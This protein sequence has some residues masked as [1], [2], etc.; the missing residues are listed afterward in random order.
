MT[1]AYR[2]V[3]RLAAG[4]SYDQSSYLQTINYTAYSTGGV[5][6]YSKQGYS[7]S[8]ITESRGTDDVPTTHNDWDNWETDRLDRIDIYHGTNIV[9]RYDLGYNTVSHTDGSPSTTWKT[10]T[11]TSVAISGSRTITPL[12]SLPTTTFTY[13]DKDNRAPDPNN[14]GSIEWAYP[15]L[16]TI[17]NGWGATST[18]IYEHDGRSYTSWY[19]WRVNQLNITDGVN[20]SPMKSTFSYSAPCYNDPS[21]YWC[22]P[23]NTG[24]LVGYAQTTVINFDFN[25]TT[26]LGKVVHMFSTGQFEHAVETETRYQDGLGV[27]VK[28]TVTQYD[29]WVTSGVPPFG[30]A[31]FAYPDQVDEY[32][33]S[34]GSLTLTD[35]TTYAYDLATGN[36]LSKTDYDASNLSNPYR[37][38]VYEYVTNPSPDVWIIKTVSK[39]KVQDAGGVVLSEQQYGYN[40]NLP[41]YTT[42][43]PHLTNKPDLSWVVNGTQT[44]DTKYHY[45]SYGN[46]DTTYK[47]KIYGTTSQPPSGDVATYSTAYDD[48]L[49][50]Y[51]I[52]TDPPIIRATTTDYDY[53]LGLP[54]T[55]TDPNDA[56]TTT[57]YDGLGRVNSIIDAGSLQAN[58]KY[59]YPTPTGSPL[60]VGAPFSVKM[61]AW[62]Q[63]ASV[64]RSSW[65]IMDG[66]GRVIQTQSPYQASGTADNLV[67]SD[68]SY[69]SQ[70]MVQY[71]GL[72]RTLYISNPTG[73]RQAPN[74]ASVPHNTTTYDALTRVTRIDYPD[75]SF[76][77]SSYPGLR[78]IMIDRNSHQKV[79]EKDAFGRLKQVEEYTGSNLYTLY[80]TTRYQYDE[81]DLL[82]Q[83]TDAAD[84]ITQI[85]YD[86]FG[87]KTEITDPDLGNWRYRYNPFGNLTVQID[88]K[89]QAINMFYD[90]LS[91]M[92]GKTYTTGP[93]NPATY[94]TPTEPISDP[95]YSEYTV[96]YYYDEET[97]GI[98]RRTH[99]EDPSGSTTWTYNELGQVTSGTQNIDNTPFNTSAT[100]D[101]FG[102]PLDS[103]AP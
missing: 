50:T 80:A 55:V 70:G 29:Y 94:G 39:V 77:T 59:T 35:R 40:G 46:V 65:Q 102:R 100:F 78:T 30:F 92:I 24:E 2:E 64:Y 23:G 86:G 72:P 37:T 91:R 68:T 27:T 99:M 32:V 67:L 21:S 36:I 20:A 8:F 75:G 97:N 38:T 79:Q 81:R 41:G 47:Y 12:A 83:V 25:G 89:R 45:D 60:S 31:D 88:A 17:S 90:D 53:G 84:N 1:F 87:R 61:E 76:E 33:L 5:V 14:G 42:P 49:Q 19:N 52:S 82:K 66:L 101:A 48:A 43:N 3:P 6:D 10:L 71:S 69:N 73:A 103:N 98:G 4:I 34:G 74:W 11:L 51:A 18:Y 93:V 9:R 56:T 54:T 26:I 16:A 63:P 62:D 95:G 58:V 15:R 57:G 22:N 96:K 44:I 13:T 28:K 85:T 7:V